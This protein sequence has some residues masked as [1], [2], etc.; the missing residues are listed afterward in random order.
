M[1]FFRQ[2][3]KTEDEIKAQ[4]EEILREAQATEE[5][6]RLGISKRLMDNLTKVENE[7]RDGLYDYDSKEYYRSQ[8]VIN[9]IKSI[10]QLIDDPLARRDILL[11]SR[12][13]V[14]D[15]K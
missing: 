2:S 15:G 9:F 13:E 10:R 3:I 7:L 14:E 6:L 12:R 4:E 1:R 8:G 11:A 5:W